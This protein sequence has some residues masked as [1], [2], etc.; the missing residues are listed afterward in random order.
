LAVE[1]D[2][3]A[4]PA[5]TGGACGGACGAWGG[6]GGAC[7]CACCIIPGSMKPAPRNAP[8]V[9]PPPLDMPC[10]APS[11]IS[12]AAYCW[13]PPASWEYEVSLASCLSCL[14]SSSARLM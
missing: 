8:S 10:P 11:A 2:A 12:P 1:H 7:C 6:G 3:Q 14:A 9:A 5:A 4:G 13:K